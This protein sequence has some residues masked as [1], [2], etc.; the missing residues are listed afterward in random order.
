MFIDESSMMP[1]ISE[2]DIFALIYNWLIVV[3]SSPA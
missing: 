1:S 2:I 3:N